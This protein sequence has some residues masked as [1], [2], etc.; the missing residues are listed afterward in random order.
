MIN[1]IYNTVKFIS[2]NDAHGNV[3]PS[4][5]N[6]ALY[7]A[8]IETYEGYYSEYQK[9]IHRENAG[10]ITHN[11]SVPS[12]IREKLL[13]YLTSE[14]I[15]TT[16]FTDTFIELPKNHRFTDLIINADN[17]KP[18]EL[19]DSRSELEIAVNLIYITP[20]HNLPVACRIGNRI[21]VFP[22]SIQKVKLFYLRTPK[23]PR[24]TYQVVRS[25]GGG[26]VELFN[27][28]DPLFQDVDMHISEEHTLTLKVL[29]SF[30]INLKDAE[31]TQISN[32]EEMQEFQ[33]KHSM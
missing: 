6:M 33:Q 26:E 22:K 18:F 21:E 1:R 17:G 15:Q 3:Q 13:Y 9:N 20:T 30:G 14:E 25:R 10:F 32:S 19:F 11:G 27:P 31:L 23:V 24:W 12:T 2:N 4:Q 8:I 7:N 16:A 28:S 29:K 5:F